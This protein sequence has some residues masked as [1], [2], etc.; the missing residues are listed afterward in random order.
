LYNSSPFV[1]GK[2]MQ[3]TI[4]IPSKNR[5]LVI[6]E[7][8]PLEFDDVF[9]VDSF[10]RIA[11]KVVCHREDEDQEYKKLKKCIIEIGSSRYFVGYSL[12][13]AKEFV[14]KERKL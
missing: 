7:V 3:V 13:E 11:S 10:S 4:V 12:A 9:Y 2:R 6:D 5:H 1:L 14:Q 8:G